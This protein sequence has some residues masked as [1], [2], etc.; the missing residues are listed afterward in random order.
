MRKIHSVTFILLLAILLIV[1]AGWKVP[2]DIAVAG[3]L[4]PARDW[5]L[6]RDE[7]NH[8]VSVLYDN[9][10]GSTVSF[11]GSYF[12]R[13]DNVEFSLNPRIAFGQRVAVGDTIGTLNSLEIDRDLVRLRAEMANSEANLRLLRAGAKETEIEEVRRRLVYAKTQMQQQVIRTDRVRALFEKKL[14]SEE[15]LELEENALRLQQLQV[16][17]VTAQMNVLKTGSTAAELDLARSRTAGIRSE[18]EI[19]E[20]RLQKATITSPI[21]GYVT[22]YLAGDSLVVVQ[23]LSR[24]PGSHAGAVAGQEDGLRLRRGLSRGPGESTTRRSDD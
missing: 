18:I 12:E 13:G 7:R 24:L 10:E 8:L 16:E 20:L 17:V 11:T 15:D 2:C 6:L 3:R 1:A 9:L 21:D 5:I 14:A 4:I 19:N 23:D 22:S